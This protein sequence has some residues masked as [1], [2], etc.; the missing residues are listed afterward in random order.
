MIFASQ[1][2]EGIF[3]F[4]RRGIFADTQYFVVI[5]LRHKPT[6]AAKHGACE[7]KLASHLHACRGV[8]N[9]RYLYAFEFSVD[10]IIAELDGPELP[11]L[12][13]SSRPFVELLEQVG[14]AEQGASR[15]VLKILK[16][17][18]VVHGK[19]T[20]IDKIYW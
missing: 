12:D 11:I 1:R 2:A 3:Q 9:N 18:E 16:P 20:I 14:V 4:V 13:G 17:V 8:K 6:L 10:N 15:R 7:A 19:K 5:T